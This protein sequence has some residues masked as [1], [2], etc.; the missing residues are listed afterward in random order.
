MS[1]GS[2]TRAFLIASVLLVSGNAAHGAGTPVGTVI[3]NTASI[4][5]DLAGSTTTVQTNT[6]SLTVV[7]RVDVI[8]TLQSGQ[9]LVAANDTDRALLFTLTNSGNGSESFTLSIDNTDASDDFDP[10]AS[11]SGIYFDTDGSGDFTVGDQ[12]YV[13]GTNDPVLAADQAIDVFLVNNIP[14]TVAN[15]DVGRSR[16][17]AISNTGTGAPGTVIAGGGDGGVDAV[18]GPTGGDSDATGEYIVSDVQLTATKSQVVND[19]FGGNQPVPGATVT[20]TITVEVTG[21]GTATASA[22]SDAIPEFTSFVPGSIRLNASPLT[23][24]A[25]DDAGEYDAGSAPTVVVRLGDLTAADGV[26]TVE[27]QVTID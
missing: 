2:R 16:I 25:G 11:G 26:Q 21:A 18:T 22:V 9:V 17:V 14:G 19:Q 7:E 1:A 24:A 10:V 4:S 8:V 23:D 27:F 5:F 15:G 6:T 13:A 12:E 20:Y 3:E